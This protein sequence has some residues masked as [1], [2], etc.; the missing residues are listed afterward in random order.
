MCVTNVNKTGCTFSDLYRL[1]YYNHS[2]SLH[3]WYS[4]TT[5]RLLPYLCDIKMPGTI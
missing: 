5:Q 3:S 4:R 2:Y 1:V